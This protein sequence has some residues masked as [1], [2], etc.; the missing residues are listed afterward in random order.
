MRRSPDV[1]SISTC[2]ALR[3]LSHE[4]NEHLCRSVVSTGKVTDDAMLKLGRKGVP[5]MYRTQIN[6]ADCARILRGQI[7]T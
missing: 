2:F 6:A 5:K 7:R 1:Q 3:H 4:C